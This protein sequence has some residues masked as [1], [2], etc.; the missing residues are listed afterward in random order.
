MENAI[1]NTIIDSLKNLQLTKEK[2]E[3]IFIS[4]NSTP[5]LLEECTLSLFGRLLADRN[6]NQRALK[7][8]LRSA[9]KLG[10]D[11]RIVEVQ[12]WG[13]PFEHMTEEASRDIGGKIGRVIEVDKRSWQA[14]Q[15]KFMRV[16]VDLLIGKPLRRGGYVT[17]MDG[18]RCWVSF[19]YER[20]PTFCFTCGKIDHDEKHCGM[21]IEKQP[22]ER[23]YGEWLRAG[24]VSKG[25]NEG[26]K[27]PGSSKHEQRSGGGQNSLEDREKFEKRGHDGKS[28]VCVASYQSR[29]DNNETEKHELSKNKGPRSSQKVTKGVTRGSLVKEL[30]ESNEDE[31][32][33]MGRSLKPNIEE[34]E[35][36]SPLKPKPNKENEECGAVLV[37]LSKRKDGVGKVNIKKSAR[38][39]GKAHSASMKN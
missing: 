15:A 3:D 19:K 7:N 38:E 10:F 39:V 18:E 6:Q 16:R 28:D 34:Q 26:A 1:E 5:D 24:G 36:T 29:W 4:S 31:L 8:M 33:L 32:D 30:F 2:E 17:N 37:G 11:L 23:Q 14:D 9:W 22:L 25:A 35:V 20:L 21:E 13:L 27:A 12:V